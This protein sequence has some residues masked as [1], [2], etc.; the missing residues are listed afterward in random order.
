M[1]GAVILW[2]PNHVK[3]KKFRSPWQ[4]TYKEHVEAPWEK[5]DAFCSKLQEHSSGL[6]TV[7]KGSRR[8]L[9]LIESSIFDFL[10]NNGDRHHY[11]VIDGSSEASVLLLDNGKRYLS[12]R[13]CLASVWKSSDRS[14][15]LWE[16]RHRLS[17]HFG[18][19]I[20]M[21]QVQSQC[22]PYAIAWFLKDSISF[23]LRKSFYQK[24]NAVEQGPLSALM[25]EI[26]KGD[27][28]YPLLTDDHLHAMD[29]RLSLVMQ[30][31]ELCIQLDPAALVSWVEHFFLPAV[32]F[33]TIH[34][35]SISFPHWFTRPLVYLVDF[36]WFSQWESRESHF[37]CAGGWFSKQE[38]GKRRRGRSKNSCDWRPYTRCR[39]CGL[40]GPK[41]SCSEGGQ[42]S[43][44]MSTELNVWDILLFTL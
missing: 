3:L 13:I 33:F 15:Q 5:D 35:H 40:N 11:E 23:R 43:E 26:T 24:L 32:S 9:D 38:E 20:P 31:V 14:P 29:R 2:L 21:L 8:L 30:T 36:C 34:A 17:W 22:A 7:N 27:D 16:A 18:A 10:I 12:K 28:L 37:L 41:N 19:V 42:V 1:E 4:R 6:Y 25:K 44:I 39:L